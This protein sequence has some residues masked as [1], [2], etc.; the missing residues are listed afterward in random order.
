[1]V[2]MLIQTEVGGR[3]VL[4]RM[5]VERQTKTRS[6]TEV[7]EYCV[8]IARLSSLP[9]GSLAIPTQESSRISDRSFEVAANKTDGMQYGSK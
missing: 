2:L 3:S 8:P 1:M 5:N 9:H 4:R 7:R 6:R